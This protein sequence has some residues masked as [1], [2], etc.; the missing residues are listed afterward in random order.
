MYNHV[1]EASS[2]HEKNSKQASEEKR[3]L[4]K[5][6]KTKEDMLRKLNL[7]K[8]YR[9]KVNAIGLFEKILA[10]RLFSCDVIKILKSKL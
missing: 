2:M 6:L 8:M 3:N 7:V 10:N 9:A 5:V 4:L 1:G